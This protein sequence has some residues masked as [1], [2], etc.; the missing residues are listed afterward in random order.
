MDPNG[1]NI[2]FPRESI[3]GDNG[4]RLQHMLKAFSVCEKMVK[5]H[6]NEDCRVSE[7]KDFLHPY[8]I[9][10]DVIFQYKTKNKIKKNNI[11]FN[12]TNPTDLRRTGS[13]GF[14]SEPEEFYQKM[15]NITVTIII[16]QE[17]ES[18]NP[19]PAFSPKE[20]DVFLFS[21]ATFY[22]GKFKKYDLRPK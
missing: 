13:G 16:E 12:L 19:F 20:A 4:K 14:L 15:K 5:V 7:R 18:V 10:S 22:P 8:C 17:W 11:Y 2:P 3:F 21:F 6:R 1:E 9:L